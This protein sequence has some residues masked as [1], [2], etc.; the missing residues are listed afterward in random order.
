M[1]I[2]VFSACDERCLMTYRKGTLLGKE[3]GKELDK[4]L[5]RR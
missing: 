3:L 4:K 5:D 1:S 2:V